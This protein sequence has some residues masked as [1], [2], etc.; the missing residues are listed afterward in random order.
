MRKSTL[1]RIL[2][3]SAYDAGSHQRWREQLVEMLPHYDWHSLALSPRYFR[4]RIRGN[5][6]TWLDEPLLKEPWD[7]I[8]ATSMVD[9][10][11]LKTF[12]PELAGVPVILY[13]HE[14]QF[15]FPRSGSQHPSVEPQTVNLYSAI[16]ADQVVFNSHWNLE[17]FLAGLHD[18]LSKMPDGVPPGLCDRLRAKS[19]VL[20]VPVED[21]LFRVR[22][23]E[24]NRSCPHLLWNHRWEYDKGP[25]RL[26]ML[27]DQL[28]ERDQPFRLSLV[29]EQ[30]RRQPEAFETIR[31]KYQ[32][33]I[34]NWG[35]LAGRDQYHQLLA[36][37]DVVISTAIHDF[38]GL[39]MI[40]AMASGCLP[41][42]PDRLAYP[43]YVPEVCLYAGNEVLP[44]MEARAA[45]ETLVSNLAS[46]YNHP[47]PDCWRVSA[48][49]EEYNRLFRGSF[50]KASLTFPRA[51]C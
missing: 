40:E 32:D 47:L 46:S 37:A 23:R 35:Y 41:L 6:L 44:D 19:R 2:I 10:A 30:F 15:A 3:L 9:L 48:L 11:P 42:A 20:P 24:I 45:A 4:W 28:A 21:Q 16:A 50:A 39:A 13:M 33:R 7:L 5:A 26:L 12:H 31:K 14:N 49:R 34:I 1:P 17:S 36:Q 8:I 18:F 25:D 38:Q 22:P 27:L 29:G 43:E 51:F